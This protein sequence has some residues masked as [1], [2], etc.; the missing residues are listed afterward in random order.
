MG[1]TSELLPSRLAR[2]LTS[3]NAVETNPWQWNQNWFS[4]ILSSLLIKCDE[5][6]LNSS[7]PAI[8]PLRPVE[9]GQNEKTRCTRETGLAGSEQ[10][11]T[12]QSMGTEAQILGE[13]IISVNCNLRDGYKYHFYNTEAIKEINSNSFKDIST[14]TNSKV[15]IGLFWHGERG[16][17][18]WWQST[19]QF[20]VTNRSVTGTRVREQAGTFPGLLAGP[21]QHM[22]LP[23]IILCEDEAR[24][25]WW[26]PAIWLIP[27]STVCLP[28]NTVF[29]S[30]TRHSR[31]FWR[32]TWTS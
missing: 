25:E 21:Q 20:W 23:C 13:T 5:C 16:L 1:L 15:N 2:S 3:E 17:A 24:G 4:F 14:Q 32:S 22:A 11:S 31:P 19:G 6:D 9:M 10:K 26:M 7:T 28:A 12:G 8:P 29:I 27:S 30:V 18:F